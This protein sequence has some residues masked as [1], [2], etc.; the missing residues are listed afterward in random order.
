[1]RCVQLHATC[2]GFFSH[3]VGFVLC[4]VPLTLM[5]LFATQLQIGAEVE[6]L[7]Q[8]D[9]LQKKALRDILTRYTE[10]APRV[11]NTNRRVFIQELLLQPIRLSLCYTPVGQF[12]EINQISAAV[13]QVLNIFGGVAK[14]DADVTLD[15]YI[16]TN[17]SE[18]SNMF[19]NAI[20]QHYKRAFE[21][22]VFRIVFGLQ[23]LGNPMKL[24]SN[25]G[26]GVKQLYYEPSQGAVLGKKELMTGIGRGTMDF[27]GG[28]TMGV[29]GL[30]SAGLET[31]ASAVEQLS[32]NPD[33]IQ[34]RQAHRARA[35]KNALH[36]FVIS[37]ENCV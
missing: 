1:M 28:V 23:T 16:A 32:F 24:F 13:Q 19:A 35:P 31:V 33:Y 30:A 27:L 9:F 15:S 12:R 8:N 22:Q 14:V 10:I 21:G 29:T 20:Q 37:S 3:D 25:L 34:G 18:N 26:T 6:S 36:G 5:L 2:F 7:G 11:V 4:P 17:V